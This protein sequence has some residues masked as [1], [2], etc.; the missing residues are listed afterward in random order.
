[1]DTGNYWVHSSSSRFV[2]NS[3]HTMRALGPYELAG[4]VWCQMDD[5]GPNYFLRVDEAGKIFQRDL[6]GTAETVVLNPK[7]LQHG[8]WP[9]NWA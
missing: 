8:L 2:T 5:A 3:F 7:D 4:Q 9:A 6:Q 1:M